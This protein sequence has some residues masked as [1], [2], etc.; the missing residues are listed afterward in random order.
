MSTEIRLL[1]RA[2]VESVCG[3]S[4]SAIYRRLQAGTFPIPVSV[5]DRGIRW[6]QHEILKWIE[7]LPRSETHAPL[8]GEVGPDLRGE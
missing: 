1:R 3:L 6:Y 8:S 4:R 5:G 2:E 7:S